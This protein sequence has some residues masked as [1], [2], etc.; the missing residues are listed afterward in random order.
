MI[1]LTPTLEAAQ[2]APS[3]RP[4]VRLRVLDQDLGATR[5]RWERWYEAA[6]VDGPARVVVL[7]D[8]TVV[9][10]RIWPASG[11]LYTSR[12]TDPDEQSAWGSWTELDDQ[13]STTPALAMAALGDRVL[14]ATVR[15][16][17]AAIVLHESSDGGATFPSTITVTGTISAVTGLAVAYHHDESDGTASLFYAQGGEVLVRGRTGTGLFGSATAWS[18]DLTS[19]NALAARSQGDIEVLVSG[20]DPDGNAGCWSVAYGIGNAVNAGTWTA[21]EPVALASPGTDVTYLANSWAFASRARASLVETYA[22]A[23]AYNRVQLATAASGAAFTAGGWRDPRP[24]DHESPYGLGIGAGGPAA[25]DLYLVAPGGVWHATNDPDPQDLSTQLVTLDLLQEEEAGGVLRATLTA[26]PGG[27]AGG[28]PATLAPGAELAFD[29][30]FVTTAGQEWATGRRYWITAIRRSRTR[31]GRALVEVEA[32]DALRRLFAWRAPRQLEWPGS[33]LTSSALAILQDICARA[34]FDLL[35]TDASDLSGDYQPAF[36]VRGGE[37][38]RAAVL[39]L[40]ER[41]PD[42]LHSRG[43]VLRLEEPDPLAVATYAYGMS[44]GIIECSVEDHAPGTGWAR[45]FG[46]AVYAETFDYDALAQGAPPL[47]ALDLN[48]DAA[49]KAQDRA[50]TAIRIGRLDIIRATLL[51]PVNVGQEV[52]DVVTVTDPTLGL[53][54]QP[55]RVRALRLRFH[56]GPGSPRYDMALQLGE[57]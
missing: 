6:A 21:L 5:L 36:T 35:A 44:H 4:D 19:I 43:S 24:F 48:L 13:V 32:H 3:G 23:G 39:R 29:P 1:T 16:D 28:T 22:G 45:I 12:T 50:D 46:D 14:V 17:N 51:A 27:I 54:A 30:G 37:G 33:A 31:D 20:V 41:I 38:G 49:G 8:G 2:Q 25:A 47:I 42:Q 40:L 52:G 34:G 10:A 9:R 55:Y 7:D 57:V 15:D 11:I 53:D 26:G 56:R 18:R